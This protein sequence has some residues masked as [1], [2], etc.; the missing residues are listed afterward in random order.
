[1]LIIWWDFFSN[2]FLEITDYVNQELW[3]YFQ[4]C[5]I[6]CLALSILCN[7]FK[8]DFFFKATLFVALPIKRW[9]IGVC[10][11]LLLGTLR[12]PFKETWASHLEDESHNYSSLPAEHGPQLICQMTHSKGCTCRSVFIRNVYKVTVITCLNWKWEF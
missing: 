4:I 10:S 11:V 1:M 3:I 6:K 5:H 7:N 12:L 9:Q 2:L 8:I